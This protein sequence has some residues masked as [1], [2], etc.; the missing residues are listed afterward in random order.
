M[1]RTVWYG[2]SRV[3][4]ATGGYETGGLSMMLAALMLHVV[5]WTSLLR[6]SAQSGSRAA[7]RP[8]SNS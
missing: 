4:S 7:T 3:T 8:L 5:A 1:L 2:V 6:R